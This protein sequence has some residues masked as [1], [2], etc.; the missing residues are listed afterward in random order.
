MLLKT[1]HYVL[2]SCTFSIK[3]KQIP[4]SLEMWRYFAE[5][6]LKVTS[7]VINAFLVSESILWK[8]LV[9]LKNVT[10]KETAIYKTIVCFNASLKSMLNYW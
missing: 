1:Q 10:K 5:L 2:L 7:G 9:A 4:F 6:T 3:K 8:F